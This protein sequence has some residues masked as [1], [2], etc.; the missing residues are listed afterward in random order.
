R[1][2]ARLDLEHAS[3]AARD[4]QLHPRRRIADRN[5]VEAS[6]LHDSVIRHE[7]ERA[8]GVLLRDAAGV[9]AGVVDA[10]TNVAE[11]ALERARWRRRPSLSPERAGRQ[12]MNDLDYTLT[13][14]RRP[15][16]EQWRLRGDG[17]DPSTPVLINQ[18]ELSWCRL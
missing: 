8:V 17:R 6:A 18:S 13:T 5:L 2:V 11:E 4:L 14:E 3:S 7:L 12:S 1:G 15:G 9:G 10:A 16:L